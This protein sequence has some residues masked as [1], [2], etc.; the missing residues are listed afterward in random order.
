MTPAGIVHERPYTC[1]LHVWYG[2]FTHSVVV[3]DK[4]VRPCGVKKYMTRSINTS[5]AYAHTADT[6]TDT[7]TNMQEQ[8]DTMDLQIHTHTPNC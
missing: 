5:V 7:L 4:D 6:F 1:I 2:N 3:E 8:I